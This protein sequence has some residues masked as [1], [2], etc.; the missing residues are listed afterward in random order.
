MSNKELMRS[1]IREHTIPRL[2]ERGFTGKYPHFRR[3]MEHGIELVSFQTNAWGGSFTVEVSAVFPGSPD[4]NFAQ[5]CDKSP[6]A[7]TVFD[8]NRRH[9]L[10]GMYDRWFHYQDLYCR[11]TLLG[12]TEYQSVPEKEA[13]AFV[14][15]KGFRLFRKFDAAQAEQVCR[16]VNRQLDDAWVWLEKFKAEHG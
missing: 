15:S 14:P 12:G 3:E 9:R 13:A 16:E 5:G 4:S 10:P 8:T 2:R 11:R 7:M 6:E 1:A